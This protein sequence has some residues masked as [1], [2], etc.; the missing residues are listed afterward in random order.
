MNNTL[1]KKDVKKSYHVNGK[2]K[3][4]IEFN[5]NHKRNGNTYVWTPDGNMSYR[6][7]YINGVKDG[8]EIRFDNGIEKSNYYYKRG[9]G[10]KDKCY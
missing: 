1:E 2:L 9:K 7:Q 5:S 6:C 10:N 8:H 3:E 4:L